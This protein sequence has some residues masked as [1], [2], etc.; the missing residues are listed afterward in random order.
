M[1]GYVRVSSE[2]QVDNFS[3]DAQRRAIERRVEANGGVLVGMYTDE[4]VSGR[5]LN[6]PGFSAML[7]DAKRG[8]FDVLVV[9][10]FDRFSRNRYDN[11][12]V[13]AMLRRDC[14]I[15][16]YSC[17]EQGA[18][19]DAAI[20]ALIEGVV[21]LIAEFYSANLAN[22]TAKGKLEAH[23]QGYHIGNEPY[24]YKKVGRD[25]V[26]D[27]AQATIVRRIFTLYATG[28][29]SVHQI[30]TL[31]N[32]EGL[33]PRT[34]AAF[35][36]DLLRTIF[37]NRVYL[38]EVGHSTVMAP[39]GKKRPVNRQQPIDWLPGRHAAIID[40][41][42][43]QACRDMAVA[44]RRKGGSP[45]YK[46]YLL[47]G[48][49]ECYTCTVV[50][51]PD[52]P[53]PRAFGRMWHRSTKNRHGGWYMCDRK[54]RGYGECTQRPVQAVVIETAILDTLREHLKP[55]QDW[56]QRAIEAI[57]ARCGESN[58]LQ[59]LADLKT[60][61]S[62]MDKRYD[63]GL[64]DHDTFLTE[65]QA[66]QSELE[67]LSRLIVVSGDLENAADVLNNFDAHWQACVGNTEQQN[68]FLASIVQRVYVNGRTPLI[69][70]TDSYAELI[71]YQF[72][73]QVDNSH[74][75]RWVPAGVRAVPRPCS[76]GLAVRRC[77]AIRHAA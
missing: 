3:L 24:G 69:Q 74:V 32:S 66:L 58:L 55:G 23:R 64:V 71:E 11:M 34:S 8:R 38:S 19:D 33:R 39:D 31:L 41:A 48:L 51:R 60:T 20:G 14:G 7:A 65:R 17:S 62:R 42:V 75:T 1:A 72:A 12:V 15:R 40:P 37:D 76:A 67:R 73:D 47:R 70:F 28:E 53:L 22:E 44:R 5:L 10:K 9:H 16:I 29:Y 61:A 27:E 30:A 56:R 18:D 36:R 43:W 25:L 68:A 77:S 21:E 13:K 63:L 46:P 52:G 57:A 54:R 4:G 59:R 26:V 50:N 2:E 6:R 45:T 49:V 35:S